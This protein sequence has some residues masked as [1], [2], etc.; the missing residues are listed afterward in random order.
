M[1]TRRSDGTTVIA[2]YHFFD[3]FLNLLVMCG[4]LSIPLIVAVSVPVSGEPDAGIPIAVTGIIGLLGGGL[5]LLLAVANFVVGWGL[6][7]RRE[8][9]RI[10]AIGLA[11]LRLLNIPIGTIIGGLIIWYLLRSETRVE[12]EVA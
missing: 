5:F 2:L 7:Q 3:G 11:V 4:I 10:S 1:T 12:F 9:A 8:W 6:W